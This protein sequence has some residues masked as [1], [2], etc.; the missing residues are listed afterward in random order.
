MGVRGSDGLMCHD[1]HNKFHNAWIRVTK[2]D[3][4]DA[5]RQ[6]VPHTII[7]NLIMSVLLMLFVE[8][9]FSNEMRTDVLFIRPM[10]HE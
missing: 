5:Q 2:G 10:Q 8:T 6:A 7:F 3:R 1:I 9:Q 4:G